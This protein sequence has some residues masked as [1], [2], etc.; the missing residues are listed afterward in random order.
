[1]LEAAFA[2]GF[3]SV[4]GRGRNRNA[5]STVPAVPIGTRTALAKKTSPARMALCIG[6]P[7]YTT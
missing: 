6:A 3:G 1:M 4:A 5:P 2:L 7:Q